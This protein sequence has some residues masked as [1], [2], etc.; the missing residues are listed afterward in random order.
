MPAGQDPAYQFAA[1]H[2]RS[3]S[4]VDVSLSFVVVR[5]RSLERTIHFPKSQFGEKNFQK[6]RI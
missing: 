4:L 5:C 3:P 1:V 6:T 2:W